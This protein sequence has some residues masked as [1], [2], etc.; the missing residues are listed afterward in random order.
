MNEITL[1]IFKKSI[2]AFYYL[3]ELKTDKWNNYKPIFNFNGYYSK[4]I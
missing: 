3:K 2:E 1:E 4:I